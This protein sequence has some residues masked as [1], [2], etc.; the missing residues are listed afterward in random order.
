MTN[1]TVVTQR[2]TAVTGPRAANR[3]LLAWYSGLNP[4]RRFL[5]GKLPASGAITAW[6]DNID[7]NLILVPPSAGG[8]AVGAEAGVKH[9]ALNGAAAGALGLTGV[10]LATMHTLVVIARPNTGD[11][12]TGS[13][14]V[15]PLVGTGSGGAIRLAQ[16]NAHDTA[17]ITS[18]AATLPAARDKWHM[19]A[20][21]IGDTGDGVFVVDGNSTTFAPAARTPSEINL[22]RN[23]SDRRQLRV[24]EMLTSADVFSAAQLIAAYVEAKAWYS[25]LAW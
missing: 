12:V 14:T 1:E 15:S 21:S 13:T 25:G 22:A 17:A 7:K 23:G 6:P 2:A 5:P 10:S 4:N 18:G 19:Y 8:V 16:G 20:W 24:Q 3:P 9:A 11:T